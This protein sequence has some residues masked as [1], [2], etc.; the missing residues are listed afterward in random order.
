[1]STVTN[2][3]KGGAW[4]T[5]ASLISK[6]ASALSLPV[7][8]RLLNPE[9]LGI[10]SIIFSLTQSI[11]NFSSLGVEIAMHRNGAQYKTVGVES[12]GRLFGVGF[13]LV[14]LSSTVTALTVLCFR[15]FVASH[16]LGQPNISPWLAIA[17][18][19]VVLQP[20]GDIPLL[21]LASLHAF[22]AYAIRSSTGLIF[23]SVLSIILTSKFSLSGAIW[24]LTL[25]A[26]SQIL[27][28][29][30]C[31]KPVLQAAGIRLRVDNFWQQTV[32]IFRFGFPYYFGNTLLGSLIHL[33][34]MGLVSKYGGLEE[35][36]HLRV[37]VSISMIVGFIP[38]AITPAA[39]SYLS[40]SAVD[41]DRS[42][43]LKCVHLRIVWIV[44]VILTGML[45]LVIP[46]IINSLFGAAYQNAIPLA[47]A[48]LWLTIIVSISSVLTQCLVAS[49][50]T[51]RSCWASTIG[52]IAWVAGAMILVPNHPGMGFLA[53]QAI[54]YI[55]MCLAMVYPAVINS[56]SREDL[57]LLRNLSIF[58]FALFLWELLL[59]Q[60]KLG[61]LETW[62]F[63]LLTGIMSV[64]FL[65]WLALN[66][67]ERSKVRK[68]LLH[69]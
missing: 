28:S 60:F 4:L 44:T 30:L 57:G 49:G 32:S 48:Q 63:M 7:L 21:F 37:A 43:Y 67:D 16:L 26:L 8:A 20:M 15:E 39:L 52:I 31:V 29:Y 42:N 54:C 13:S 53:S 65:Y 24:G 45:S 47:W 23:G 27:W 9:L 58:T 22:Q 51:L 11:R 59:S 38:S 62:C 34:L 3:I 18:L 56:T 69:R 36:G 25:T 50:K 64:V 46:S 6:L 35:L 19:T 10:Y 55:V 17:S 41:K 1:M 5:I 14:C 2:L 61:I 33:P 12:V 40:T 66:S 68:L